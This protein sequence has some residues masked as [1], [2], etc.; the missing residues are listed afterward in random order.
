MTANAEGAGYA[1]SVFVLPEIVRS[2]SE[3]KITEET[4]DFFASILSRWYR[5]KLHRAYFENENVV[6]AMGSHK[7][8]RKEKNAVVREFERLEENM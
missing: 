3:G 7:Q 6:Y 4:S 5:N 8:S 2:Y 1:H